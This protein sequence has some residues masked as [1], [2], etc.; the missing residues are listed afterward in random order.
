VFAFKNQE[1]F[2]ATANAAGFYLYDVRMEFERLQIPARHWRIT[3]LN[4]DFRI[5]SFPNQFI[6]PEAISDGIT[7]AMLSFRLRSC[8]F[9]I[10][11]GQM[12]LMRCGD[13]SRNGSDGR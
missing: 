9:L 4:A 8:A 7:R 11:V 1:R 10:A 2:A 3:H 5:S 13:R 12:K 6:V